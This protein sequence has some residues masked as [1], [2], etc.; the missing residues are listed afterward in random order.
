MSTF[1]MLTLLVVVVPAEEKVDDQRTLLRA[2]THPGK[3]GQR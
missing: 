2:T 3:E 1:L